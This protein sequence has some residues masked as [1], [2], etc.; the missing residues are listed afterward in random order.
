MRRYC[1]GAMLLDLEDPSKVIGRLAEPLLQP[2]PN[3]HKGYVPDVVYS[4]GAMLHQENLIL[5]YAISDE[6]STVAIIRLTDLLS[7]LKSS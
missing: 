6:A 1:I 7:A 4:C 3:G 2:G 5:P